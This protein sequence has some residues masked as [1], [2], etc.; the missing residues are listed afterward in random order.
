[1]NMGRREFMKV[2]A[3]SGGG[4]LLSLYLTGC[5]TSPQADKKWAGDDFTPAAWIRISPDNKVTFY[6]DR[7]EMGQGVSTALPMLLAEELDVIL[8]EVQIEF[9]RAHSR[10]NYPPI[11]MMITGASASISES[12]LPMRKAGATA[13]LLLLEAA[14]QRWTIDPSLCSTRE[15]KVVHPDG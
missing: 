13:R 12:F 1:M 3:A 6:I 11:Y 10:Y 4:L 9:A 8:E 14:A 7:A 2:G 15:G 5:E